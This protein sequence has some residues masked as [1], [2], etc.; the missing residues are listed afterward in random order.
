MTITETDRETIRRQFWDWCNEPDPDWPEGRMPN[1]RLAT[2]YA[3]LEVN[4]PSLQ[5]LDDVAEWIWGQEP[6]TGGS[7]A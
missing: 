6:I 5:D 7:A 2:L 1:P 4:F 3:W